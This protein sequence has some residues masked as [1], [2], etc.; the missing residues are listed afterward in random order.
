MVNQLNVYSQQSTVFGFGNLQ[1]VDYMVFYNNQFNTLLLPSLKYV[2][3]L[4]IYNNSQLTTVDFPNLSVI[5]E[6]YVELSNNAFSQQTVDDIL[7]MLAN[8]D[9]QSAQYPYYFENAV[10]QLDGGTNQPPSA[11]GLNAI[12]ILTSR[13][14]S[15]ITN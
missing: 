10:I 5:N 4:S 3:S 11:V 15:V 9:G 8:M 14:C 12:S 13:G 7:V 2:N 6:T 1:V